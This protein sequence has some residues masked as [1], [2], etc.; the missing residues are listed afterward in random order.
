MDRYV[1]KELTNEEF[2]IFSK[3][4]DKNSIFQSVA[5]A[6]LKSNWEHYFVGVYN[7]FELVGASMV[8]VRNIKLGFKFAYMPRGPL[9]DFDDENMVKFFFSNLKTFLSKKSVVLLKFDP[10]IKIGNLTFEDKD[11]VPNISDDNLINKMSLVNLQHCGYVL[12]IHDSI[13]PRIQLGF[14]IDEDIDG[15]IGRKTMK[16][17]NASYRKGV[18][19]KRENQADNLA[20][21]INF[22]EQRHHIHLR[23]KNYFNDM[24]KYFKDDATVLTAYA[25]GVAIS[26]SLLVKSKDTAEILYSG[27]NDEYKK[28]NSTYPMRYEAILWAKEHGC[29]TFNFGGAEGSLDDGLTMFKSA[30]KPNIDI[31]VGEFNM[32]VKPVLGHI[33]AIAFKK[34]R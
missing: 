25:E 28:F 26:S 2:E 23:N 17:V 15:R 3:D 13:Q 18:S 16:K 8:L 4:T 9:L 10:N 12:S 21:I 1:F 27:Y 30:F 20:E 14:I 32:A 31:Y 22:T 7:G 5:W 33:A 29:K 19:L 6:N 11:Q 24:L 34:I